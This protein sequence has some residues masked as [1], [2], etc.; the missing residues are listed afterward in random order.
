MTDITFETFDPNDKDDI[1]L[2]WTRWISRFEK[3][4]K[5]ANL[6]SAKAINALLMFAGY[7]VELIYNEKCNTSDEFKVVV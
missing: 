7:D 6:D 5:H 1:N 3:Y 4:T 2:R